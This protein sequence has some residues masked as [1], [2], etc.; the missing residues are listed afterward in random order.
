MQSQKDILN[1]RREKTHIS[2]YDDK[3]F[4]STNNK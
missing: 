3:T 1:I 4:I 2:F